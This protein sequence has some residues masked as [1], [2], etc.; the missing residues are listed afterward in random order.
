MTIE[1][2]TTND[3]RNRIMIFVVMCLFFAGWFAHDGY[4]TYPA[5]NIKWARQ[6]LQ[7][8]GTLP[9]PKDMTT[10]PKALE[11]NL[12]QIKPG[13][14]L[15]DVK[16]ILGE[17]T[18]QEGQDY[19]YIGPAS[20]GWFKIASDNVVSVEEVKQNT[21]PSESDIQNQKYFALVAAI[22]GMVAL[23][24]LI[25]AMGTRYILNDVGL[26]IGSK[27]ITWENMASLETGEYEKKGWLDL[28]YKAGHDELT[29]RL[30]SYLIDKFNEIVTVI[31]EKKGFE[32][33]IKS[34]NAQEI[35]N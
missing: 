19:C 1:S 35:E 33:P 29:V 7:R 4:K 2:R 34:S 21:E 15:A 13:M 25:R 30:D 16:A 17:P 26:T 12:K 3:R 22:I 32:S 28:K 6:S 18:Y 9:E 24:H 27:R 31:C 11:E 8:V 23:G 14:S 5:K 20:Y 10:N